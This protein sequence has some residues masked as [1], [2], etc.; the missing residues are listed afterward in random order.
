ML[1]LLKVPHIEKL[2]CNRMA[3]THSK[4]ETSCKTLKIKLA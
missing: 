3:V 4:D 1:E 2:N